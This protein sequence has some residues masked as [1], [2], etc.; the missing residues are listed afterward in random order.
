MHSHSQSLTNTIC[1]FWRNNFHCMTNVMFSFHS[2]V[3]DT[4]YWIIVL[5]FASLAPISLKKQQQIVQVI[6]NINIESGDSPHWDFTIF[7]Y[8]NEAGYGSHDTEAAPL[9]QILKCPLLNR[10]SL[11]TMNIKGDSVKFDIKFYTV[12]IVLNVFRSC[13]LNQLFC[14]FWIYFSEYYQPIGFWSANKKFWELKIIVL[15]CECQKVNLGEV[16][17]I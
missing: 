5:Q 13:Y 10:F 3:T 4:P 6:L 17:C 1:I 12:K 7:S 2:F 14:K 15:I 11:S 9:Y 16:R 8:A